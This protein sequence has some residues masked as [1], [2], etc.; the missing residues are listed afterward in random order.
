MRLQELPRTSSG[1]IDRSAL[2]IPQREAIHSEELPYNQVEAAIAEIWKEALS[3]ERIG[4]GENFFELGGNSLKV[5]TMLG[6]INQT[7]GVE[8]AIRQFFGSPTIQ[9]TAAAVQAAGG[10]SGDY[11]EIP[12]SEPRE[13]YPLTSSQQ[14]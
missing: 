1:K 14:R 9:E 5:I 2:P 13:T 7:F 3:M 12:L 8:M 6:K 4:R 11:E 10:G